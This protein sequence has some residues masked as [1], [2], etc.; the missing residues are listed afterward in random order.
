MKPYP[1]SE[2]MTFFLIFSKAIRDI[3]NIIAASELV[4]VVVVVVVVVESVKV[5]K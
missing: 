4:V 2:N 1:F 3:V 5:M